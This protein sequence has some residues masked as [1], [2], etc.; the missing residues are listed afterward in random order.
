MENDK[1]FFEIEFQI[2]EV[3]D[4]D[5]DKDT[6]LYDYKNDKSEK[7]NF[8]FHLN[9]KS[10]YLIKT[11][12]NNIKLITDNKESN[13]NEGDEILFRIRKSLKN[14]IYE[15][16]SPIVYKKNTNELNINYLNS[17]IWYPVKSSS[18]FERNN[19][20][21]NL[22]ENDIIKFGR[23]IY[24]V[25]KLHFNNNNNM[26]YI[27][28]INKNSKS[29][30]NFDIKDNQYKINENKISKA[31]KKANEENK[32]KLKISN[33]NKN[34]SKNEI[35]NE[36]INKNINSVNTNESEIKFT[37]NNESEN[38]NDQCLLCFYSNSDENNPLICLCNCRNYIHYEC[39]KMYLSSKI[40]I[41]ENSTKT[42]TTYRCEK[43]NC[44]I[45]LKPYPLRF[46]IPKFNKTYKLID[47]N[48]PEEADYICLES[49]DYIKNKNNIKIL[50]IIQLEGEKIYIG[51]S[52]NN[53]IVENDISISREHA[54]FIYNKNNGNL[55][56]V[57]QNSK[58]GSLVLVRGNIKLRKIKT[59]FQIGKTFISIKFLD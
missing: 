49:L 41:Y 13:S 9:F 54:I 28:S 19:E 24:I 36:I 34:E 8:I 55:I 2:W 43:F 17:K 20:N 12:S 1:M 50:H 15:V 32:Q 39:L 21:Y 3:N 4:K 57:D 31:C 47:L 25:L 29:I 38:E 48:F 7:N 16:I 27:S 37:I 6:G 23:K 45:C 22:N 46:R 33:E 10:N 42:V 40:I 56:L 26:S 11:K 5:K 58:F 59:F 53:D 30:F 18:Y 51:R 44:D 52:N 14:S 35:K